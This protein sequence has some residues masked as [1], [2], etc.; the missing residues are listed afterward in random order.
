MKLSVIIPAL[1]EERLIE[2]CLKSIIRQNVPRNDYEIIVVDGGS[3]D[4]TVKIAKKYADTVLSSDRKGIGYQQNFGARHASGN[5]LLF[6]H[7]DTY[8]ITE[9]VFQRVLRYFRDKDVV[10]V[11]ISHILYPE[12]SY[13][14]KIFNFMDL[15]WR[16]FFA[17]LIKANTGGP[18]LAV[19]R[20]IFEEI[21][22]FIEE[23]G[24]DSEIGLRLRKKGKIFRDPK[25]DAYSSSR[26][27]EKEGALKNTLKYI[28]LFVGFIFNKKIAISYPEIRYRGVRN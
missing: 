6:L 11:A 8:L 22:G 26:R 16:N 7:A 3:Q 21:G 14:I 9:R 10:A 20:N 12:N 18:I 17:R 28:L 1:N 24:E 13:G 5:I 4:R 25:I 19:R 15:I 23:V 27:F 2:K